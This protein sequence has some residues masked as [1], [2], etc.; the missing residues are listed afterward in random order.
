MRAPSTEREGG[1]SAATSRNS[2]QE[3]CLPTSDTERLA[4]ERIELVLR[5]MGEEVGETETRVEAEGIPP[6]EAAPTPSSRL[7][8]T[9]M[10]W[11]GFP[12]VRDQGPTSPPGRLRSLLTVAIRGLRQF[13]HDHSDL[14]WVLAA[15]L[16]VV[17]IEW[18]V[19]PLL[20]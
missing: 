11:G 18:L 7:R 12:A 2:E 19:A 17:V 4:A 6:D 13:L 3:C 8:Q 16:L 9:Q 20:G 1:Y 14:R 15:A 10:A 5:Y